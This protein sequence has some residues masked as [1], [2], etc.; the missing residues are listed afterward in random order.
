MFDVI[1]IDGKPQPS[2]GNDEKV[3]TW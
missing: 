2:I 3:K 1:L